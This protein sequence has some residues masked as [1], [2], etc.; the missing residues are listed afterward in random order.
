MQLMIGSVCRGLNPNV[1]ERDKKT[2]NLTKRSL[3]EQNF[4]KPWEMRLAAEKCEQK[5]QREEQKKSGDMSYHIL[6]KLEHRI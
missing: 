6:S 4:V 5:C 2:T 1:S 3:R